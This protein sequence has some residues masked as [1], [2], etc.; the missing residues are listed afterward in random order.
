M[1]LRGEGSFMESLL[2]RTSVESGGR[3]VRD[4]EEGTTGSL[5]AADEWA[6]MSHR[7]DAGP[8]SPRSPT[9]RGCVVPACWLAAHPMAHI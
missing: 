1:G 2:P 8:P 5:S 4:V 6:A 3:G 7:I 9:P